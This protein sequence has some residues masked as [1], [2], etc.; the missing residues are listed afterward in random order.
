MEKTSHT[1]WTEKEKDILTDL[2]DQKKGKLRLIVDEW[3]RQFDMK[4]YENSRSYSG[5]ASQLRKLGLKVVSEST[6]EVVSP[7]T[8]AEQ[9]ST[10]LCQ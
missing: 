9:E 1:P 4:L 3:K 10:K 7:A 6:V 2:Y 8:V 5:I